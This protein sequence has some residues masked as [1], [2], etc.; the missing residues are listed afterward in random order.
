MIFCKLQVEN[1]MSA[2]FGFRICFISSYFF[3]NSIGS[4]KSVSYKNKT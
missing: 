3:H 4:I 1:S 2:L